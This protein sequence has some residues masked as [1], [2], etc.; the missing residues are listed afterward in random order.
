MSISGAPPSHN[1]ASQWLPSRVERGRCKTAA[2]PEVS[3]VARGL[4]EGGARRMY[5]KTEE[6]DGAMRVITVNH[7]TNNHLSYLSLKFNTI[8]ETC[9]NNNSQQ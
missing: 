4:T 6:D 3:A 8:Y 1:D 9:N 7:N 2:R 5:I